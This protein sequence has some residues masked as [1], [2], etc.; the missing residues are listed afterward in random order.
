[1]GLNGQFHAPAALPSEKGPSL[2]TEIC[3]WLGFDGLEKR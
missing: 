2:S 3:G 1:M